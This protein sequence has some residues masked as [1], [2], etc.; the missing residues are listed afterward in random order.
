MQV[1]WAF[2]TAV[3]GGTAV[4]NLVSTETGIK[5]WTLH[6]VIESLND[7][8]ELDNRDGHM[9]GLVSYKTQRQSDMDGIQPDVLVI[10]GGHK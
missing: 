10:G 2:R 9:T 7:F 3:A 1:H 8:P 6:T 4:A 5:I